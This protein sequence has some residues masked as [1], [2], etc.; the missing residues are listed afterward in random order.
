M[1]RPLPKTQTEIDYEAVPPVTERLAQQVPIKR[2]LYH[3]N[4]LQQFKQHLTDCSMNPGKY[5]FVILHQKG[6]DS[7][8]YILHSTAAKIEDS[9]FDVWEKCR[10]DIKKNK[11]FT[12]MMATMDPN[13][14]QLFLDKHCGWRPIT[15]HSS[16]LSEAEFKLYDSKNHQFQVTFAGNFI[17][18]D[19]KTIKKK[20]TKKKKNST[21]RKRCKLYE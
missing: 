3:S 16:L 2:A 14:E 12:K 5:Y 7:I 18:N 11:K 15:G 8:R 10:D 21:R 6:G 9:Q 20:P 4:S 1:T 19:K 17:I 13:K